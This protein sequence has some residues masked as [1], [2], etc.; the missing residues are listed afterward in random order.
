MDVSPPFRFIVMALWASSMLLYAAAI[1]PVQIEAL[2]IVRFPL[3]CLHLVMTVL[4]LA[5]A[6]QRAR[7]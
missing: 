6:V 1:T 7:Y 5:I 4:M 3:L 2:E